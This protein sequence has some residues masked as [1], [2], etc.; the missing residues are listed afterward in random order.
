MSAGVNEMDDSKKDPSRVTSARPGRRIL[1]VALALSFAA[2]VL[3][4]LAFSLMSHHAPTGLIVGTWLAAGGLILMG[5]S[6]LAIAGTMRRLRRLQALCDR[7]ETISAELTEIREK[8]EG[9]KDE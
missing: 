1:L 7:M 9:K 8:V 6:M 4:S 3:M 2:L 5:A